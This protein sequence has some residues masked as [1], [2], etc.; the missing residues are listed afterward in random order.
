MG[1]SSFSTI[2]RANGLPSMRAIFQAVYKNKAVSRFRAE[3]K[4]F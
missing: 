4:F 2:D 1:E 3:R